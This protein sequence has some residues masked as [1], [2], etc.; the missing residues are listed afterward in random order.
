[1]RIRELMEAEEPVSDMALEISGV[2]GQLKSSLEN[3]GAKKP[4][5]LKTVLHALRH[6]KININ[7]DQFKDM[8]KKPPLKNLIADANDH[9]VT[10]LGHEVAQDN[11]ALKPD[12]T[13]KTLD[14]MAKRAEKKR[15]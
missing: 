5:S 12:Q 13:T 2:L 10:F 7:R 11:R 3:S 14:K 6:H 9:E 8:I 1:M 4:I 15:S